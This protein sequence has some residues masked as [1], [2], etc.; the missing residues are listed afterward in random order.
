MCQF[1]TRQKLWKK[2]QQTFVFFFGFFAPFY[3]A[4]SQISN[5]PNRLYSKTYIYE[6]KNRQKPVLLSLATA[7]LALCQILTKGQINY[8]DLNMKNV[9]N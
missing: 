8:I 5:L 4:K 6:Q 9:S 3:L 2:E 1:D 7:H